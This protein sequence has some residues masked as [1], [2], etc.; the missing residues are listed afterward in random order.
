M[1]SKQCILR[2]DAR[3]DERLNESNISAC[4]AT[5][6]GNSV[7]IFNSL[8]AVFKHLGKT[9]NPLLIFTMSSGSIENF[10]IIVRLCYRLNGSGIG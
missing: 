5:G 7:S 8:K 9:V 3:I 1:A 6:Y 10:Y 2:Q 4:V